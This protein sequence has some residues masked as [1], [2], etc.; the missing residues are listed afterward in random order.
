MQNIGRIPD[1]LANAVDGLMS[2][3]VLLEIDKIDGKYRV[4]DKIDG[5][6]RDAKE[7]YGKGS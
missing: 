1:A 3:K 4:I 6:Y 2:D 7:T 5:E